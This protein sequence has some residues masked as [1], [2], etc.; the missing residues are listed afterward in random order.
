L[1]ERISGIVENN[2]VTEW[3]EVRDRTQKK[4]MYAL[5][6]EGIPDGIPTPVTLLSSLKSPI[7]VTLTIVPSFRL[8]KTFTSAAV[9][10]GVQKTVLISCVLSAFVLKNLYR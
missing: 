7:C 1:Y 6:G 5:N 3:L 10:L 9:I 8:A 4:S 2:P